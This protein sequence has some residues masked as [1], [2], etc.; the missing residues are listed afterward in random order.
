MTPE[1]DHDDA[2][3]LRDLQAD[4]PQLDI[5]IEF[6]ATYRAWSARGP[7]RP[8][9]LAGVKYRRPAL[10][11]HPRPR[12]LAALIRAGNRPGLRAGRAAVSGPPPRGLTGP[13]AAETARFWHLRRMVGARTQFSAGITVSTGICSFRDTLY[14][15]DW[16]P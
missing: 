6:L 13:V 16:C 7:R 10:P 14:R 12:R 9:P 11:P 1:N 4:F 15:A 3:T 5:S 2:R 8:Q